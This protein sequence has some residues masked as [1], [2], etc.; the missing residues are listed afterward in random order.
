M[1]RRTNGAASATNDL[2]PHNQRP[3]YQICQMPRLTCGVIFGARSRGSS[4]AR[5][6][7]PDALGGAPV[8]RAG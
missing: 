3:T 2:R 8:G 4:R 5:R 6:I 1:K 7:A